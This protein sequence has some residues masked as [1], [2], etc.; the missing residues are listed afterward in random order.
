MRGGWLNGKDS[1]EFTEEFTVGSIKNIQNV[2]PIP[3]LTR[4]SSSFDE[5]WSRKANI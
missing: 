5:S 4:D 3:L 1:G 2:T